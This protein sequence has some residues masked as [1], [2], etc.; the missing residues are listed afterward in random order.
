M[1]VTK[2]GL[3]ISG[4]EYT[5]NADWHRHIYTWAAERLAE[6]SLLDSDSWVLDYGCGTGY[7]CRILANVL[8]QRVVGYDPD[9]D[10]VEF[11]LRRWWS[12]LYSDLAE[13]HE[14]GHAFGAVC[15]F[16]VIEHLPAP[17]RASIEYLLQLAPLVIGSVPFLEPA[18]VNVHHQHFGLDSSF[19]HGLN[20]TIWSG[21]APPPHVAPGIIPEAGNLLFIV[22]R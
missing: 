8:G 1:D 20:V 17:P 14:H 6:T 4:D 15:A 12:L 16:E 19:L 13:A 21:R 3:R 11:G 5:S 22:R 2:N 18:G 9:R 7:G 10:A